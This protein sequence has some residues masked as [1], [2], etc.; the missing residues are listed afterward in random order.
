MLEVWAEDKG[1]A[2]NEW[3]TLPQANKLGFY[4]QKGEHGVPIEKFEYY[5]RTK[6]KAMS[7]KEYY[8]RKMSEDPEVRDSCYM[9]IKNYTVFNALQFPKLRELRNTNQTKKRTSHMEEY[10]IR[11]M[12]NQS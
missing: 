6:G 4:L 7:M 10:H 9:F 12:R 11:N 5:D 8:E 3:M 1:Y 2:S